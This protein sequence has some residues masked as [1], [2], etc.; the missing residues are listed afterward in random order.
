[1]NKQKGFAHLGLMIVLGLAV[2]VG[3]WAYQNDELGFLQMKE[4][5][6]NVLGLD[7]WN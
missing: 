6:T 2:V 3:V 5:A 7:F 4:F 1:M